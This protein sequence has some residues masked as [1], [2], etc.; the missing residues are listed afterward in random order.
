MYVYFPAFTLVS[1]LSRSPTYFEDLNSQTPVF[2]VFTVLL[3][4][5]VSRSHGKDQRCAVAPFRPWEANTRVEACILRYYHDHAY[6]AVWPTGLVSALRVAKYRH[7]FAV[8]GFPS[9]DLPA[10]LRN[11]TAE[12]SVR[13]W[14]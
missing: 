2:V 10:S 7:K 14:V 3:P 6:F 9:E 11:L 12:L 4:L 8:R 1:Y 13:G 5:M